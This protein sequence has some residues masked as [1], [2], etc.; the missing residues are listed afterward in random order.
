MSKSFAQ[1]ML[2]TP[3]PIYLIRG[4]ERL[5]Y[6]RQRRTLKESFE[7]SPEHYK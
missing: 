1:E 6:G 7:N 4:K 3:S 5:Q 2:E